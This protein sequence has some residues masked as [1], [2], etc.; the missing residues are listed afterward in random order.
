MGNSR[1]LNE[2]DAAYLLTGTI[3]ISLCVLWL[4]KSLRADFGVK[5]YFPAFGFL[6]IICLA[7]T[8]HS[9]G[10]ALVFIPPD[11]TKLSLTTTVAW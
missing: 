10:T 7:S 3:R 11:G 4:S 6:P 8:T 2:D 1:A 5:P 9:L